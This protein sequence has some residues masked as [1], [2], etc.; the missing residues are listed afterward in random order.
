MRTMIADILAIDESEVRPEARFFPDLD[1][2]SL[3]LLE[4]SF[5]IEK[6]Y[7]VRIDFGAM[8]ANERLK[9]NG[10]VLTPEALD[11]L[12][13]TYPFVP[14]EKLGA[15][16]KPEALQDA[17]TVDVLTRFVEHELQRLQGAAP[18]ALA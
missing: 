2:E 14:L 13:R 7:G 6:K 3:N 11:W 4:L 9:A 15:R 16:P 12:R 17:L 8:L 18:E 1:G 5:A 10:G